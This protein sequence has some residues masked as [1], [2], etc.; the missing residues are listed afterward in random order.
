M[1]VIEGF[2][3]PKALVIDEETATDR[4]AR[5]VAE[6]WEHGYGNTV[7]NALRRVLL[8][9]ME[10][11]AVSSIRID[12][13]PHEFTSI[14]DVL[15]DVMDIVLNVKKLKFTCD[16]QLPRTL[17]V[18]AEKAGEVTGRDICEDG[19]AVVV[20]PDQVICTLDKERPF[21]MEIE[22][23]RGRGYRPSELNKRDDQPLG[24]IPVDCLF[25]PIERVSYEVQACRVGMHTDYDRLELCV[26]TDGR[27]KPQEAVKKSAQI[28]MKHLELFIGD[29]GDSNSSA[30]EACELT[31]EAADQVEKLCMKV[32]TL[33]L[34]VRAVNVLQA[35]QITTLGEL[36]ERNEQDLLKHR[37]C[38]K[39]TVQE[40][41][42]KLLELKLAIG[43]ELSDD[44]KKE[45]TR[46]LQ[47]EA[48]QNKED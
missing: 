31:P 45:V 23:D 39:K 24:T 30:N 6:P 34:S 14:P 2:E 9:S 11:V 26:W 25:S 37:N 41:K 10:G 47:A 15:E 33:E 20:N 46:R 48:S 16:G 3:L 43:M 28:L 19:V 27:I 35:L 13:V 8:S 42:E 18:V 32:D 21:R 22:I 38:G 40:I 36:I 4:F 5:F 17:Q 7:G 1:P 29:I 44:V 12:G